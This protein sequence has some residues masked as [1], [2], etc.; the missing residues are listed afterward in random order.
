MLAAARGSLL[1]VD[2]GSS[3]R[4]PRR[5]A[6][7]PPTDPRGRPAFRAGAPSLLLHRIRGRMSFY[8]WEPSPEHV[9]N[10]NV[11]R[12]MRAHGI[13]SIDELRRRSVEDIA[14]YWDAAIKDL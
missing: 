12:L 1:L 5:R 3:F 7:T 9:E 2:T 8:A 13:A 6:L 11:T 14:W 10:A 4:P